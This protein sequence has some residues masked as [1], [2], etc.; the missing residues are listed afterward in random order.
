MSKIIASSAIRGAQ[1]AVREAEEILARTIAA[2]GLDCPVEFPDTAYALPVIYSLLGRRVS[3]LA[4]LQ[5]VLEECRTLLPEVPSDD[6]WLPYLGNTLDAGMA[7][8]FA[9]EVIEACKYL[10]GPNPGER[11][12]ARRGQRRYYS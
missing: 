11:H 1:G 5:P 2:K 8:L 9:F 6:V 3:K 4:E 7:T 10:I 12:L